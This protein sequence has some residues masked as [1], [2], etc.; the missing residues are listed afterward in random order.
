MKTLRWCGANSPKRADLARILPRIA[1]FWR[2][3]TNITNPFF[4]N[5]VAA[6]AAKIRAARADQYAARAAIDKA[7][8]GRHFDA[9]QVAWRTSADLH[10]AKLKAGVALGTLI[11]Y[12]GELL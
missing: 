9:V 10:A 5:H 12:D 8:I 3:M 2:A 4:A 6:C 11:A 1:G 7:P